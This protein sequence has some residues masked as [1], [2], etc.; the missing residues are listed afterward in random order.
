MGMKEKLQKELD[1]ILEK[2]RFWR[3]VIFGIVSGTVGML[4][5][6]SQDK[7]QLNLM[8]MLFLIFGFIG[9]VMFVKRID[10]LTEEYKQLLEELGKE[11]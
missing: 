3:Y 6:A 9:I 8:A 1:L 5:G 11:E 7:F 2:I 10:S 4:F